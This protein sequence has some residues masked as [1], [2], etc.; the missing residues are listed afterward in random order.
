VRDWIVA[1]L[2]AGAAAMVG[3]A[4]ARARSPAPE[5]PPDPVG[6]PAPSPPERVACG[7]GQ[8]PLEHT[9]EEEEAALAELDA[10][11]AEVAALLGAPPPFEG[12]PPELLPEGAE[13]RLQAFL[14]RYGK[15]EVVTVD[16]DEYP[17]V[18]AVRM[19]L[20]ES[21]DADVTAFLAA[22]QAEYGVGGRFTGAFG[23]GRGLFAF[24][25]AP[26]EPDPAATR[27]EYFRTE[28]LVWD[29][30]AEVQP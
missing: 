17:C 16:C 2:A 25:L 21:I 5:C 13:A 11:D 29:N 30:V 10:V 28:A 19:A 1:A 3:F 15:G 18:A 22:V 20:P 12:A 7:R 8:V 26:P 14:S 4:S 9:S 6:V 27:R 24:A 23:P